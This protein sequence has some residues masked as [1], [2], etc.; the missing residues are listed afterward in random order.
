MI[1][2]TTITETVMRIAVGVAAVASSA[3]FAAFALTEF[4]IELAWLM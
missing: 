4:A 3:A 1:G 2:S